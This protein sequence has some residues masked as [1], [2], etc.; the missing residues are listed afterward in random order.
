MQQIFLQEIEQAMR[1]CNSEINVDAQT[2]TGFGERRVQEDEY[3]LDEAYI[4]WSYESFVP[5]GRSLPVYLRTKLARTEVDKGEGMREKQ[6][7]GANG[8]TNT[9]QVLREDNTARC[10][11]ISPMFVP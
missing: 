7:S 10:L 4:G 6:E 11:R 5:D 2:A 9:C 1:N 3:F 8:P